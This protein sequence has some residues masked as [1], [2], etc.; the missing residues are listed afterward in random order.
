MIWKIIL[1]YIVCGAFLLLLGLI[2]T[3]IIPMIA[4]GIKYVRELC[5]GNNKRDTG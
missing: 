2:I 5:N 1:L 4:F 3:I